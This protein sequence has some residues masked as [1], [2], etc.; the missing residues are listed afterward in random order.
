V[1]IRDAD[2]YLAGVW[3]WT[4]LDR[5]FSDNIRV[6]DLDGIVERAGYFLVIEGKKPGQDVPTGQM[7]MFEA[8]RQ[9][10]LFTIAI[11]WGEAGINRMPQ[12]QDMRTATRH[13]WADRQASSNE[14]FSNFVRRWF[15]W[16]D[17]KYPAGPPT[18]E[19]TQT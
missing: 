6:S 4:A 14:G 16:A 1:T 13:S 19:R 2:Q 5:C 8:M 10:G 9:T 7:R 11:V 15:Q 18:P 12:V 3:E 17:V